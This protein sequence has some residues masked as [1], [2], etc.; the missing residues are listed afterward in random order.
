MN[1]EEFSKL[2]RSQK[3]TLAVIRA[4]QRLKSFTS[5]GGNQWTRITPHFVSGVT[6]ASFTY[7]P[8]NSTLT[9]TSVPNPNT[10]NIVVEYSFFFSDFPINQDVEYR[11][12]LEDIGALKLELDT[13][14]TGIAIESDSS[15]KLIN[16]DGFF[17]E[18]FDTLTWENQL[19]EFYS[20]SPVI[21]WSE[22]KL[23]Y[24]GYINTKSFSDKTV[25]FTI[26]D[27]FFKL[28]ERILFTG[29]RIIYGKAKNLDC[30]S[31]D[32]TGAGIL[33]SGILSGRND[34]DLLTGVFSGTATT[35]TI[36]GT[37]TLFTTQL[38]AGSKLRIIDG[39]TEYSYTVNTITNDT[40]LTVNGTISVTFSAAVG[41]NAEIPNNI[42]TG[43]FDPV[44]GTN[45]SFL[46]T[47]SSGDTITIDSNKYKIKSV[48][49]NSSLTIEEQVK[50]AFIGLYGINLP[51]IN[52]RTKN[53][54]WSVSGYL[55]ASH[56][57]T[58][59][60]VYS[61]KM[62]SVLS[63]Y[64]ISEGDYIALNGNY[65][66]VD[67]SSVLVNGDY[68]K[69]TRIAGNVITI[70]QNALTTIVTGQ[71]LFKPAIQKVSF[72]ENSFIPG[73][74]FTESNLNSGCK[75]IFQANAEFNVAPEVVSPISFSFVLGSRTVTA[76]SNTVTLSD[77]YKPRD[78]IKANSGSTS[79]WNEIL[80]VTDTTIVLRIAYTEYA[81]FTGPILC[82]SPIVA[83]DEDPIYVDCMGKKD[84][85]TGEWL[86]T[87]SSAIKDICGYLDLTN[88]DTASFE[89][90]KIDAPYCLNVVYPKSIDD[91]M[92]I[93]RDMITEINKSVFGS[94]YSNDS[95]DIAYSILSA[96]RD[97]E[98]ETIKDDDIISF[99]TS[100]KNQ[101]VKNVTSSYRREVGT[102]VVQT[103]TFSNENIS[104]I[105][106]DLNLDLALYNEADAQIV[107]QRYAFLRSNSQTTV[108]IK[109]KLHL[110]S[111][112]LNSRVYLNLNRL[113]KR[114]GSSGNIK[115][116]LVNMISKDS[117]GVDIQVNDIGNIF[118][119]VGSI[120][121]NT[122]SDY[123]AA[124]DE[125]K[126]RYCYIVDN[127]T[128]APDAT[129]DEALGSNL[130]G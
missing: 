46:S 28:R 63:A 14:N 6:G 24:K 59:D 128:E 115:I 76:L 60:I 29:S 47:T 33:L 108:N 9:I 17:D 41:R 87:A 34:R 57:T 65:I 86:S 53:R 71:Y 37:G 5:I 77:F 45:S 11:A 121:P 67:G 73:R 88:L 22:R 91:E 94:L 64:H 23:I 126:S 122:A 125:E 93:A 78:W 80:Q 92:P 16:T 106:T 66:I 101:I 44:T 85:V 18:I 83:G 3:V 103:Y 75:F 69:V 40:S 116:G 21:P 82:K 10:L 84:T 89:A 96:D 31:L 58:V 114:F 104:K 119:R 102:D 99:T 97:E 110:V 72:G 42:I 26:K 120:A 1:Y 52:R 12:I 19:C 117:T 55:L 98:F 32:K 127:N 30:S 2:P 35:N 7:N 15:I 107:T 8:I 95:F 39:I 123:S 48:E 113:F 79:N 54:N 13:E 100:T 81:D 25:T 124:T 43:A 20:W 27:A 70:N 38:I 62:F 130:I 51:E 90:A 36:A 56:T 109:G 68:Y 105:S 61:Q 49:S 112:A 4:K 129:N 118:S 74:D 50:I 111:K